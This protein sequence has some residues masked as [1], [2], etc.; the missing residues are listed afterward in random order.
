MEDIQPGAPTFPED[1]LEERTTFFREYLESDFHQ[2]TYVE[3]IR[4]LLNSGFPRLSVSLDHLR[5]Y[6]RERSE[7]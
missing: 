2:A 7:E 1:L 6:N 4:R 3:D 5:V